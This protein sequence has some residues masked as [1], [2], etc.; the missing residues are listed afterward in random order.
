MLTSATRSSNGS[1]Q[2]TLHSQW[3]SRNV[4]T[5]AVAAS[6]PRTRD[7]INPSLFSLRSTRT[8]CIRANSSP[9]SAKNT[10]K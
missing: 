7:R 3:E 2:F 6:A 5:E 4:N 1:N 8:L 9:S 10:E